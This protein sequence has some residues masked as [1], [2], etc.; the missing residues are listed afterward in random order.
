MKCLKLATIGSVIITIYERYNTA[1]LFLLTEICKKQRLYNQ[2]I[3]QMQFYILVIH[4]VMTK[5]KDKE[6]NIK[7]ITQ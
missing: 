7:T 5:E 4:G 6:V 1:F 3:K 2:R